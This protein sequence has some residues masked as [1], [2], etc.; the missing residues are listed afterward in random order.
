M[1]DVGGGSVWL[2]T[3]RNTMVN[4]LLLT[5]GSFLGWLCMGRADDACLPHTLA[6]FWDTGLA[7]LRVVLAHWALACFL[8]HVWA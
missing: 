7:M 2:K 6:F 1:V 3:L 8:G 4:H 5:L